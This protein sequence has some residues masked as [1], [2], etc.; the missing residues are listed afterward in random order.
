MTDFQSS[1]LAGKTGLIMG[2]A[3]DWSLAWGIA[4]AAHNAGAKLILTYPNAAMEKRVRPLAEK[5]GATVLECDVQ[6]EEQ[7]AALAAAV[8]NLDFML[9]AIAFANKEEL[10]GGITNTTREGFALAMDVSCYSFIAL[11]KHLKPKLNPNA[12][13]LTLTYEGSIK[14]VPNYNVMG[15]AKAALEAAVRYLAA[16]FGPDSIRVNAIS[17]GSVNTLAARG[18]SDF[19]NMLR[20]HESTAPLRRLTTKEDVAGAALYLLSSLGSGTTGE[21]LNVD[22]GAHILGPTPAGM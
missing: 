20:H 18:I 6:S 14:V 9:H 1:L 5:L 2:V 3:N 10:K 22:T 7:M 15:V 11:L 19:G 4:E 21:V 17:A 12:S 8:P 13:A 16:E